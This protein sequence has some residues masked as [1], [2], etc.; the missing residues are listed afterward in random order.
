[1]LSFKGRSGQD[2]VNSRGLAS[3][4]SGDVV[5]RGSLDIA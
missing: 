2:L 5:L 1:M 4:S 3:L